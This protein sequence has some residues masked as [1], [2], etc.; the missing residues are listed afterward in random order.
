M[1]VPATL[2]ATGYYELVMRDSL[3]A[4]AGGHGR[5]EEGDEGLTRHLTRMETREEEKLGRVGRSESG[6]LAKVGY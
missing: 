3:K 6:E 5:H 4:L 1:N 2:F